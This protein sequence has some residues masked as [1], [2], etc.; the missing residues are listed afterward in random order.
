MDKPLLSYNITVNVSVCSA[1]MN[2]LA[3][4]V[5]SISSCLLSFHACLSYLGQF[6]WEWNLL[7]L[8]HS[9]FLSCAMT[10]CS[11]VWENSN[12][13]FSQSLKSQHFHGWVWVSAHTALKDLLKENK[14]NFRY[15]YF[16]FQVVLK[17]DLRFWPLNCPDK[18]EFQSLIRV[19][20][21]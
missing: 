3:L 6:N 15:H 10:C 12:I 9:F 19:Q 13:L 1:L 14:E 2:Q 21:H 4:L 18:P 11:E 5:R 7:G 20:P 16:W 17:L 8:K